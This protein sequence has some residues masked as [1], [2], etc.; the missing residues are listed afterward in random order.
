FRQAAETLRT[1]G[2]T[3][4]NDRDLWSLA[5]VLP[6]REPLRPVYLPPETLDELE[7]NESADVAIVTE[8]AQAERLSALSALDEAIARQPPEHR[9]ILRLRFWENM[10]VAEIAR[11]LGLEQKPLYRR[12]PALFARLRDHLESAG[13]S[14]P[15]IAGLIAVVEEER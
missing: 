8:A 2:V 14:R 12:L 7:S 6:S 10:G 15:R 5:R 13:I 9:I 1:K 3:A 11:T 4:L